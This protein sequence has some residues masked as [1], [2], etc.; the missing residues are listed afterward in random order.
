ME[1]FEKKKEA[2]AKSI[3]NLEYA[4]SIQVGLHRSEVQGLEKKLDEI[5]ENFNV[6]Q[7][8]REIFDIERLRVQKNVEELCQAKDE[9]YNV[10]MECCNKLK[11][12]FAKVGAFFAKQN[13]ICGDP[14]GL[15]DGSVVKPKLLM[16]FLVIEEIF[17]PKLVPEE[18][19]HSMKKLVASML[20]L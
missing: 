3:A 19:S 2:D 1:K 14:D 6:E 18:S 11:N 4:L 10:A 8:K 13:F 7:A 9:C 5:T 16:K 12:S 20:R 15:S 17:A